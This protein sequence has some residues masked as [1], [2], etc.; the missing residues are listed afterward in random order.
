MGSL[1]LPGKVLLP[2]AGRPLVGH[3]FDRMRACPDV[4]TLVVATTADPRND[5]LTAFAADEGVTVVRALEEDDIAA[6]LVAAARLTDADAIL[7][8]NGDCPLVDP[9][10]LALLLERYRRGDAD[11]VSNKIRWT[12]PEGLSAEV[13]DRSALEWC[14]AHLVD[15]EK[16]ELVANSIRDMPERFRVV[17]VEG[18]RD[19]S[20]HR[21]TVDTAED[22][23][24]VSRLFDALYPGKPLFGLDDALAWMTANNLCTESA[25]ALVHGVTK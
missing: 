19:L 16:R 5:V 18:P 13:I 25:S 12:W 9:G 7:K 22:Y 14:D 21:W 4:S 2:L 24:F 3:I 20:R 8:V 10:I 23:V 11:Y 6:R 1:R 17:S 15:K